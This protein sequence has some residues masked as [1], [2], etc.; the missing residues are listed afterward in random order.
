MYLYLK[1]VVFGAG[2]ICL[3][4]LTAI[5]PLFVVSSPLPSAKT[6]VL[7]AGSYEDR[8]P[9]VVG[10]FHKG[11][12]EKIVVT[13]DNVRRGWS[14]KYQRNL[15]SSERTYEAL[16]ALGVPGQAIVNLPFSQSGT[17]FDALAVRDYLVKERVGEIMLVTSDYHTRRTLWI[18]KR[19]LKDLPVTIGITPAPSPFFSLSALKEPFKLL[20]YR[21]RY[22]LLNDLPVKP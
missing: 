14:Q 6:I 16:V 7:L 10:L 11:V 4:F 19:V 15:Y 8:I 12:A 1:H 5:R 21:L 9:T 13:D 2:I 3:L 22:G 17:V 18:F 20:Y